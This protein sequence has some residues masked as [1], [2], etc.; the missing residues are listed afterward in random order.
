[1]RKE[2]DPSLVSGCKGSEKTNEYMTRLTLNDLILFSDVNYIA[3]NKPAGLSTLHDRQDDRNL[4]GMI[5]SEHPDAMVAHRLDKDTSGVLMVALN[6][7][8]YRHISLQFE[9]R[10][11]EKT[12]HAVVQ[13]NPDYR[14][15]E[16][17]AP[18]LKL[19]D[20]SVKI[21][22]QGKPSL[23][24]FNSIERFGK[25]ALVEALPVTGRTHQIRIHL[26][27]LGTPIAGDLQYGGEPVLLSGLKR[28]Y[29]PSRNN[30]PDDTDDDIERPLMQRMALHALKIRLLAPEGHFIQAEAPYPK[31]F[32]ALVNQL[33]RNS[34]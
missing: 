32:K 11:V 14:M 18:I 7:D 31:D 4:L 25:H 28:G 15:E 9:N 8:A 21:S 17:D 23:T 12:Y 13:G 2:R 3:L 27:L 20:G 10:Q 1:M 16:V 24:R 22:R 34:G 6:A 29:K 19:P 26:S 33:R 30:R 5:R